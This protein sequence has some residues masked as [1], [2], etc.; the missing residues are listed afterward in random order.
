M[1]SSDA[2]AGPN[3][4]WSSPAPRPPTPRVMDEARK[5]VAE[6]LQEL[7][8]PDWQPPSSR[9]GDWLKHI[10]AGDRVY[11]RGIPQPVEVIT[12]LDDAGTVEVLLGTMRARMSIYQLDRPA[13]VHTTPSGAGIYYTRP[14]KK[15][16]SRELDLHGVRVEEAL[17]QLE[18]YL[19]DAA[20]A[21]LSSVRILHG[22]GTGALRNAVRE[23]LSHHPL[24]RSAGR[25]ET[26]AADSVTVVELT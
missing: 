10:K 12:P 23:H 25:D 19:S 3:A 24:V 14:S 15:Q 18:G 4:P 6:V 8:S 2:S 20:V 16:V 7:R 1:K 21:G 11:L 13:P 26:I 9:R 5:E 17:E 22:V